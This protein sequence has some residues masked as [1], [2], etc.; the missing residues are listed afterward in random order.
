M[1]INYE[2]FDTNPYL[3]AMKPAIEAV[4]RRLAPHW[5]LDLTVCGPESEFCHRSQGGKASCT[6]YPEYFK[7][8]IG[9]HTQFMCDP[10]ADRLRSLVHEISHLYTCPHYDAAQCWMGEE[11]RKEFNEAENHRWLEFA[12]V[13]L[14]ETFIRL[15]S[16]WEIEDFVAGLG[17]NSAAT[18]SGQN[19]G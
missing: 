12:T 14:E 7:A 16:D 17:G 2:A 8:V 6:T 3:P 15:L 10:P 13:S 18:T 1:R 9:L 11:K 4:V 19:G 5:L